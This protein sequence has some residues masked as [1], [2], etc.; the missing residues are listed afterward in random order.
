MRLLTFN[1]VAG[2]ELQHL[3]NEDDG[4]GKFQDYQPLVDVQMG[5]LEDHLGGKG[6]ESE[7]LGHYSGEQ[8][9]YFLHVMTPECNSIDL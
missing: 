2:C 8:L 7:L 9:R 1:V 5:Q 3:I 4:E 6:G